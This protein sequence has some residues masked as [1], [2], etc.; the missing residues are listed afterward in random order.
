VERKRKIN[1]GSGEVEVTE[2]GFRSAGENFQEYL[3]DD[4]S[5]LRVKLVVTNVL[6]VDGQYDP[7]GNPLYLVQSTNVM[8]VSAP[9]ELKRQP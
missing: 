8:A 9:E 3:A 4:G 2:V 1:L 5:V 6:R 7:Q